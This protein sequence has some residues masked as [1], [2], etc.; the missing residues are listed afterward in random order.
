M[1]VIDCMR[2]LLNSQEACYGCRKLGLYWNNNDCTVVDCTVIT[3]NSNKY[4]CNACEGY[5]YNG[6]NCVGNGPSSCDGVSAIN[7]SLCNQCWML[8]ETGNVFERNLTISSKSICDQLL[9]SYWDGIN[10]TELA[11]D[12]CTK[13]DYHT[14]LTSMEECSAC[15]NT[16]WDNTI[17]GFCKP[18]DCTNIPNI[19]TE[20]VNCL[21]CG[22]LRKNRYWNSEICQNINCENLDLLNHDECNTC[23]ESFYDGTNCVKIDCERHP[24]DV[25]ERCRAC[26]KESNPL[27]WLVNRSNCIVCPDDCSSCGTMGCTNCINNTFWNAITWNCESCQNNNLETEIK[28]NT[29]IGRVYVNLECKYCPQNCIK[30]MTEYSCDE[31][32]GTKIWWDNAC[33]DSFYKDKENCESCSLIHSYYFESG[34]CQT[35]FSHMNI[36]NAYQCVQ[37]GLYINNNVMGKFWDLDVEECLNCPT[38]C[39]VCSNAEFCDVCPDAMYYE[40]ETNSCERCLINCANCKTSNTCLNCEEGFYLN[41]E[42]PSCNVCPKSC[43]MC[44]SSNF[45]LVCNDNT[46]WKSEIACI[47]NCNICSTAEPCTKCDPKYYLHIDDS[48][49][50]LSCSVNCYECLSDK[51]CLTCDEN[52]C[53]NKNK[54]CIADTHNCLTCNQDYG[55]STYSCE[56]CIKNYKLKL[57]LEC[58]QNCLICSDGEKCTKCIDGYYIYSFFCHICQ[59]NCLEC[60]SETNCSKCKI[61]YYFD[62]KEIECLK[63]PE[64]CATCKSRD[65]CSACVFENYFFDAELNMC[66]TCKNNCKSCTSQ[67]KCVQCYDDSVFD[68]TISPSS[69]TKCSVAIEGCRKCRMLNENLY[70][71]NCYEYYML[72]KNDKSCI[73]CPKNCKICM[74]QNDICTKCNT[75]HYISNDQANCYTKRCFECL[76]GNNSCANITSTSIGNKYG[77][78]HLG[79][80]SSCWI[81]TK[82]K[83]NETI[84]ISYSRTCKSIKCPKDSNNMMCTNSFSTNETIIL[85]IHC[86]WYVRDAVVKIAAIMV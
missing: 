55:L 15:L 69:C 1:L 31:C 3:I 12:A 41:N 8:T 5:Y 2:H 68:T 81:T 7:E 17:N 78:K 80:A 62:S 25:L 9:Q 71:D 44:I 66:L 39:L 70:C 53:L 72:G 54:E 24:M 18:L 86:L 23:S 4:M 38:M 67:N 28:C 77:C 56:T 83:F 51:Y 6:I 26:S 36:D 73:K 52:F 20:K 79:V 75:N 60:S 21:R 48:H 82:S 34:L 84:N 32:S 16:Y 10:C 46:Y 13:A 14:F 58:S 74:Q 59:E 63:C 76:S 40:Y 37:C 49:N 43:K 27:V 61:G 42:P 30:C 35:C 19:N 64:N 85:I 57:C 47:P 11:S 45:C 33:V 22:N 29:C 65:T 50:C